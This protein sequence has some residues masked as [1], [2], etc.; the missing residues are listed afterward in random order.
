[1]KG[2]FQTFTLNPAVN[3]SS[4]KFDKLLN[5]GWKIANSIAVPVGNSVMFILYKE[6][7]VK[8]EKG[9]KPV[10]SFAEGVK[11]GQNV[12]LNMPW[13]KRLFIER[14]VNK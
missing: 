10:D 12:F 7:E 13:Y 4:S 5:E 9:D 1:M 2:K 3:G 6:N 11:A 14:P 8:K